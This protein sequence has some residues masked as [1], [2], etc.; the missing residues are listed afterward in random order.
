MRRS[1]TLAVTI[2]ALFALGV[3]AGAVDAGRTAGLKFHA[4]SMSWVSPQHGWLLGSTDCGTGSCTAT[5]GTTT[6]GTS[7]KTLG[8]L[9]AP[10][11]FDDAGGVT[12]LRF[13]DDLHGWAFDPALWVTNDGGTSWHQQASPAGRPVVALAANAQVAYS[14]VSACDYNQAITDCPHGA[15]LWR[16]TPGAGGW[17]QVSLR[18]PVANQAILAVRGSTAYLVLPTPGSPAGDTFEA[19]TD[20]IHWSVRPDPCSTANG[21]YLSS[22]APVSVTQVAL[23]CQGNIGFGFADKRVLR[24][25]DTA[26][27]TSDAGTLNQYGIVSQLTASPNGTLLVASYSIGSWIYRNGGGT[28][29]T[30]SEDLG[31]GGIGWNDIAFTTDQLAFVVH[32][33]AACCGNRGPGEIWKSTDGGL[34]WRQTEVAPQP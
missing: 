31:D 8:S 9:A 27:T 20:G 21:E 11:T 4:Q 32:G 13:A 23:L 10:V 34:T 2:A 26:L 6:G 14:V 16:T 33:P 3:A 25:S 5:A 17:T 24:S 19:T 18:L 30:T 28:T 1:R 12:E 29:W 22:V 15:T 7:W